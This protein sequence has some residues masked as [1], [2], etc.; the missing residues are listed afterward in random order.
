MMSHPKLFEDKEYCH[1]RK[2]LY[3]DS[4]G[5]YRP[6]Q[7]KSLGRPFETTTYY[8]NESRQWHSAGSSRLDVSKEGFN[9][10]TVDPVHNI[11]TPITK[12]CPVITTNTTLQPRSEYKIR[13]HDPNFPTK[14]KSLSE[15]GEITIDK[16]IIYDGKEQQEKVLLIE[17]NYNN[18]RVVTP[19][20]RE[21]SLSRS[22][23]SSSN[24]SDQKYYRRSDVIYNNPNQKTINQQP[25]EKKIISSPPPPPP[26]KNYKHINKFISKSYS[27]IERK[28]ESPTL[29]C[30][31]PQPAQ[32]KQPKI[33]GIPEKK[34][35]DVPTKI[36]HEHIR[37]QPSIPQ[38][39]PTD[40]VIKKRP[41]SSH[42]SS[43]YSPVPSKGETPQ[44]VTCNDRI[45]YCDQVPKKISQIPTK[46]V[47]KTPCQVPQQISNHVEVKKTKTSSPPIPQQIP[48]Q[49]TTKTLYQV[50][51]QY[52]I[53]TK[54][55]CQVSKSFES[56]PI[57]PSTPIPTQEVILT[58]RFDKSPIA[59]SKSTT[60]VIS[61]EPPIKVVTEHIQ[62]Q[63]K[64]P[65]HT[66]TKSPINQNNTKH[67]KCRSTTPVPSQIYRPIK[68]NT[69]DIPTRRPTEEQHYYHI[70]ER[71]IS[72]VSQKH[73]D[74]NIP[75]SQNHYDTTS[76][77]PS[78]SPVHSQS[79]HHYYIPHIAQKKEYHQIP[80]QNEY[81]KSYISQQPYSSQSP[82]YPIQY[83][84]EIPI[85]SY[86]QQQPK[87]RKIRVEEP[88]HDSITPVVEITKSTPVRQSITPLPLP[89]VY[90]STPVHKSNVSQTLA[91][92]SATDVIPLPGPQQF[93][94]ESKYA[95]LPK[96]KLTYSKLK[97]GKIIH[98]IEEVQNGNLDNNQ[99]KLDQN[100]NTHKSNY[101]ISQSNQKIYEKKP[102]DQSI[103]PYQVYPK[104][105]PTD[106]KETTGHKYGIYDATK[107]STQYELSPS[108][109]LKSIPLSIGSVKQYKSHQDT[110]IPNKNNQ[111][112]SY[113]K[114]H[115]I[116][117]T[118]RDTPIHQVKEPKTNYYTNEPRKTYYTKEPTKY[119]RQRSPS[120]KKVI[121]EEYTRHYKK[122]E[123]TD[124]FIREITPEPHYE[125]DIKEYNGYYKKPTGLPNV[126]V[127]TH[128][129]K[130]QPSRPISEGTILFED[131][132]DTEHHPK[133]KSFKTF[134]KTERRPGSPER[135]VDEGTILSTPDGFKI[136]L[137]TSHFHSNDVKITKYDHTLQLEGKHYEVDRD[138]NDT[139]TRSFVRKYSIPS[140]IDMDSI[141]ATVDGKGIMT[142][143]G[144]YKKSEHH[145]DQR[146]LVYKL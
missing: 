143:V 139:V 138:T 53:S 35:V 31:C 124:E 105:S 81:K 94:G 130:Q 41:I 87:H 88:R 76:S 51:E 63:Y 16:D 75:I 46:V 113:E 79:P 131:S 54:T 103:V 90:K 84:Q 37:P 6:R 128:Y 111:Y 95:A 107:Y 115:D 11:K 26:I 8:T 48:N 58:K 145:Y 71:P 57:K 117:Y 4:T 49:V 134:K 93:T 135:L 3:M 64:V 74:N 59:R 34:I 104:Y 43:S 144:Y 69:K 141:T 96:S 62:G 38:D 50:P 5:Q 114:D 112:K 67:Y 127:T 13:C 118:T 44:K 2:E 82:S 39:T 86:L 55:P 123:T 9:T 146:S 98:E 22:S 20:P 110:I 18:T 14:P 92:V 89:E 32:V 80:S 99:I 60:P 1:S 65:S 133:T 101:I 10:F 132:S 25:V 121:E 30:Q 7:S 23:V 142:I 108:K 52:K 27:P 40:Q 129:S 24:S 100:N 97:D 77:Y 29:I 33:Y 56:K 66:L 68:C 109:E 102:D 136:I 83:S 17:D 91:P 21:R 15:T 72:N 122:T 45:I 106:K 126:G 47:S 78:K 119:Y 73:H 116:T 70:P 12:N 125:G 42:R 85:D 120:S 61:Q 28:G 36:V 137:D 140:D 19:A